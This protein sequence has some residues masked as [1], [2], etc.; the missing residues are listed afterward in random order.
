M[1]EEMKTILAKKSS[2]GGESASEIKEKLQRMKE[3]RL[4]EIVK[5]QTIQSTLNET[6]KNIEADVIKTLDPINDDVQIKILVRDSSSEE[7]DDDKFKEIFSYQIDQSAFKDFQLHKMADRQA[8]KREALNKQ[9]ELAKMKQKM[10]SLQQAKQASETPKQSV[11]E[12]QQE[13]QAPRRADVDSAIAA[14][15]EKVKEQERA[16]KAADEQ[17]S[18]LL[19]EA[20]SATLIDAPAKQSAA[21]SSSAAA[22]Q[23]AV[24]ATLN[25][26]MKQ[27]KE[28]SEQS[29]SLLPAASQLSSSLL[30]SLPSLTQPATPAL[31]Q[32]SSGAESQKDQV[33]AKMIAMMKAQKNQP[34]GSLQRGLTLVQQSSSDTQQPAAQPLRVSPPKSQA[35]SSHAKPQLA[36]QQPVSPAGGAAPAQ[37]A[38]NAQKPVALTLASNKGAAVAASQG[39]APAASKPAVQPSVRNV[40]PTN[41]PPKK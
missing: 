3:Q 8:A 35:V 30:G 40:K 1:S 16:N 5:D 6:V 26:K 29:A 41:A 11:A 19:A 2:E 15:L 4:V 7:E 10:E 31:T 23:N 27:Q 13:E 17:K 34:K 28:A 38:S 24:Q 22:I 12:V 14:T 36:V 9:A 20:K 25:L 39:A 21:G 18:S 37:A 33:V 32:S